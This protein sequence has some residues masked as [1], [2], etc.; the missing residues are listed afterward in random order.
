[1]GPAYKADLVDA[2]AELVLAELPIAAGD[3]QSKPAP[4]TRSLS[5]FS[6]R[7]SFAFFWIRSRM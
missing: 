4:N 6:T 2:L 1:M 5:P 3:G 7:P